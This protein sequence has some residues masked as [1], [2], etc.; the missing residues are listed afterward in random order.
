ME[1]KVGM[2]RERFIDFK[3]F[4]DLP[5]AKGREH[6]EVAHLETK[7]LLEREREYIRARIR[8]DSVFRVS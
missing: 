5:L 7:K 1:K 3:L 8:A 2:E 4:S 6:T